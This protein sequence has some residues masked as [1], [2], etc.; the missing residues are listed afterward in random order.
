MLCPS[1]LKPVYDNSRKDRASVSCSEPVLRYPELSPSE[2][3]EQY[4]AT[5]PELSC[6]L[7]VL[8]P[9]IGLIVSLRW[10]LPHMLARATSAERKNASAHSS[11]GLVTLDDHGHIK[12]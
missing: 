7:P 6:Y 11:H 12:W 1:S 10:Q 3:P 5:M 8:K 9:V 4:R 2:R